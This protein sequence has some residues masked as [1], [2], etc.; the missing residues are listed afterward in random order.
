MYQFLTSVGV[1][2]IQTAMKDIIPRKAHHTIRRIANR[3]SEKPR[4]SGA[5][6]PLI[7]DLGADGNEP[8]SAFYSLGKIFGGE[9]I[10]YLRHFRHPSSRRNELPSRIRSDRIRGVKG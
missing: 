3:L 10:P 4:T 6:V 1:P 9:A 8:D 2:E 7:R 5:M